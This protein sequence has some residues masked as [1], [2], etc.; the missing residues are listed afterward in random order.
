MF[1]L[2]SPEFQ[3]I[4]LTIMYDKEAHILEARTIRY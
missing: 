2:F 1:V 3:D 4:L